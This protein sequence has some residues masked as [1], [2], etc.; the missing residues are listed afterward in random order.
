MEESAHGGRSTPRGGGFGSP[1]WTWGSIS[2][3]VCRTRSW[4]S[5]S[6]TGKARCPR[7]GAIAGEP[8]AGLGYVELTGYADGVPAGP[9]DDRPP[10]P[11]RIGADFLYRARR[12]GAFLRP[13][14][15]QPT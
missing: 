2:F 15:D 5:P 3:R 4:P 6:A 1:P 13:G 9:L 10:G 12:T 8:A 7:A 14:N 11:R